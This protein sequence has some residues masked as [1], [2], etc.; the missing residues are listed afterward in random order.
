MNRKTLLIGAGAVAGAALIAGGVAWALSLAASAPAEQY[1]AAGVHELRVVQQGSDSYQLSF[2]V[3]EGIDAD[4]ADLSVQLTETPDYRE[5]DAVDATFTVEGDRIRLDT[6]RLAAGD[7]FLW[8]GA[9]GE[10]ATGTVTI[11]AMAPRV[12]LDGETP[13]I[14]FDQAGDSSW[15]S[16]VDPEGKNVYRSA[17]AVFDDAATPL[18]ESLPITETSY[19]VDDADPAL[20]YYFLVFTGH[21]GDSTFVSSPLVTRAEQGQLAVQLTRI[22]GTPSYVISGFLG[23]RQGEVERTHRLRVGSFDAAD[24]GSTFFVDSTV[25]DASGRFRFVVPASE[26]R[27]GYSDLAVFLAEDG[28]TLEWSLDASGVDMAQRL[29]ADRGVF[30]LRRAEALQLTR[31]DLVY[32]R[33]DVTLSR[34]GASAALTVSGAFAPDAADVG[35]RLVVKDATGERHVVA[36][37]AA[38]ARAFTYT[39]DLAQLDQASVWYDVEFLDPR[40]D[41][42]S[43]ISTLSVRDM[44]QWVATAS[45]TYAFADYDGLLK[46]FFDAKPFANATVELTTVGGTPSLVATG[47]LVGVSRGD[48]ALRIRTGGGTVADVANTSTTAGAF[49]FVFPLAQLTSSG[50]WY[51]VV[52][53]QIS[54]GRLT[55]FPASAATMTQTLTADHRDYGFREWNGQLKVAF[56]AIPGGVIVSSAQL[57]DVA[58]TATLRVEGTLDRAAAGDVRLRIRSGAELVDVAATPLGAGTVRFE[59][60]LAGLTRPGSWYDV[61]TGMA[62]T[63]QFTDVSA[64]VADLTQTLGSGGRD[65]AFHEWNGQLKVAFEDAAVAF[66]P[67]T[68]E[69]AD[70][71]GTPT[72]RVAG[73]FTGTVNADTFLRI[74]S[75]AQ[76]IDVP[77]TAATEGQLEFAADLSALTEAGTWYDLVLGV[78]STG[79][80]VDLDQALADLT[81]SLTA[82]ARAYAF[83][84]YGGDLK[85]AFV[86]VVAAVSRVELMEV[87][88]AATLRATGTVAGAANADTFLR[89]RTSAQTVNVPNTST[90][91]GVLL[92]EYDLARLTEP[93]TWYDLLVGVTTTG[94]LTDL[95][96]SVADLSQTITVGDRAYA[97]KSW[98]NDLKVTFADSSPVTTITSA[99]ITAVAGVPTLTL[100]GTVTRTDNSDVFLRLFTGSGG[101]QTIDVPNSA[102]TAGQLRFTA[103]VSAL[104]KAGIWY[105]VLVGVTSRDTLTGIPD[106]VA[107]RSQTVTVDARKYTFQSYD[108]LL[109]VAFSNVTLAEGQSV[110]IDFGPDDVTNGHATASPDAN[111]RHWNN[112]TWVGGASPAN[113]VPNGLAVSQLR[114]T[115]GTATTT[116]V[117]MSS[118]NW[119]SNGLTTG[120]L[121]NPSPALL[122]EYAIA[123]ATEDYFFVQSSGTATLTLSGLDPWRMYDLRFFGTR[124]ATGVRK[125]AYTVTG[126]NGTQEAVLQ[127]SGTGIGVGGYNGNNSTIAVIQG[128]QPDSTGKLQLKVSAREDTFGYLGFLEITGG[129]A[130]TPVP[131]EV[132]RWV[133]QDAADPLAD[134]SVLFIGSSSIRR[135][136]TLTR[137]FADYNVIQRG[138]GGSWLTGVNDY[139]PWV[140]WPYQPRAIVMWAGTNDLNGGQSAAHVLNEYRKF[141]TNM[142]AN[143]PGSDFFWISITPNPGNVGL[144][145]VR[146]QTNALI[147][148]EIAADTSGK[149]HYIDAATYFE[150]VRDTDPALFASYYVDSLHMTRAGYA[151][152]VEMVRPALAAVVPPNKAATANPATLHAG[153]KLF[154]DFGPSNPSEGDPTNVD[155]NGNHWNNWVP[156]TGGDLVNVGEHIAGLVDST[157]RDTH[158]G[159]TIA[160][161][162]RANGKTTGGLLAPDAGLLGELGVATATED[163]FYSSADGKWGGSDDDLPGGLMMT[164]LDPNQEYEFRFFGSRSATETRVTEYAVYGAN[165]G[166]A[167]LTTSGANISQ[168]GTKH[169]NDNRIAV[170]SGIR[171]DAFGQ[172]WIDLTVMQGSYAYLNA[173]EV[174]ASAPTANR[175]AAP[176]T[177]ALVAPDAVLPDAEATD[178]AAPAPT[179]SAPAPAPAPTQA[180]D[181]PATLPGGSAPSRS[182]RVGGIRRRM[183]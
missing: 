36:D 118:A 24:P 133:S 171:P 61:L 34:S 113:K 99:T 35:Y 135:W 47:S 109:K 53:H 37:R 148:A 20:P 60:P 120:G 67:T 110:R 165:S 22:D 44:R 136:E 168:D 152:W 112:V 69:I 6:T 108:G 115:A 97:F 50:T 132:Q 151:K 79:R 85:V 150:N 177:D 117:T 52:F 70:V 72:L 48:A 130:L 175:L 87:S 23:A 63:Q 32:E 84:E 103:D 160:A 75:G 58:G 143:S 57:V 41:S 73:T 154:F 94:Q 163:F 46:V 174:I 7:H 68:V 111:G 55:D 8:V 119:L 129:T 91:E 95:T 43:P 138:W 141:V 137:D 18:A 107:D 81:T 42:T 128:A 9:G 29:V 12:W 181:E 54:T 88:G 38:S 80:L 121:K 89:I 16:Y 179:A 21:G 116:G 140:A 182:E 66:A 76:T 124:D 1:V 125:T 134:D 39:L 15:S 158:I 161:G 127:T 33:L 145:A 30:G 4:A 27:E 19:R 77:N 183:P 106:S 180:P 2:A 13:H 86:N 131:A 83:H 51:D 74:R 153:E 64:A 139:S 123:S 40:D 146:M 49:R 122:G 28:A 65:Y 5:K 164:G 166:S 3:P 159:M 26:L 59:V 149:L 142:R 105:D 90:T 102:T 56:D 147:K 93:G 157:G 78:T 101:G 172:V 114:T 14:E 31:V 167:L 11:P 126:A 98:L 71:A 100:T 92:F 169:G 156:T 176:M 82:N 17:S 25:D 96:P 173:M 104:T 10:H 178:G 170:V 162:F 45:R 62:S 144:N 155:A